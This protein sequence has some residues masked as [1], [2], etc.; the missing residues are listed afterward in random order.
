MIEYA[1]DIKGLNKTYKGTK[2]APP[3]VALRDVDLQIPRGSIFG[4]LGPNGAGKTTTMKILTCYLPPTTGEVLVDG[5]DIAVDSLKIREKIGYLPESA[6]VYTDM[7]VKEYLL[8][9]ANMHNVFG[10]KL[11]VYGCKCK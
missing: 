4:L 1:I 10:K 6:P 3:N 7:T 5:M 9:A 8:F 11:A 2:K